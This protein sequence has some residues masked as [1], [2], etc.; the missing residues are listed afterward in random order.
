[1]KKKEL[2]ILRFLLAFSDVA[3]LNMCLFVGDYLSSKYGSQD[4]KISLY[5]HNVIPVNAIWFLCANFFRLYSEYTVY[6]LKD[7]YKATWRSIFLFA[8]I[9]QIYTL[10]TVQSIFPR[11]F[12]FSFYALIIIIFT[13]SRI[14][15]FFFIKLLNLNL[16]N[17]TA[18][19]LAIASV[20]GHWVELLRLMPLFKKHEVT[21]ISN[22][23]NLAHSVEGNTFHIVPDANRNDPYRMLKCFLAIMRYIVFI[24]PGVIITTGAAP[25][26]MG[27]LVGKILG[28]KTIWIDSIANVDKLSLSG[29]IALRIADKVYTQWEHL[30]TS[31]VT[32]SGSVL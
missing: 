26:L 30:A 8:V 25:G 14:S 9:F 1:M 7:I 2:G 27:I 28:V 20:G 18:S 17:R 16:D 12:I 29:N 22:K 24:R 15:S 13:I 4:H 31:K 23:A 5:I 21:F 3:L 11:D 6:K 32:F 19:I 10:L